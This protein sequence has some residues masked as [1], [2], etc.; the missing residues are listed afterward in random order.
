MTSLPSVEVMRLLRSLARASPALAFTLVRHGAYSCLHE[1]R[2]EH[3][4]AAEFSMPRSCRRRSCRGGGT[5]PLPY[6]VQHGCA[7]LLTFCEPP[8]PL[9][10]DRLFSHGVVRRFRRLVVHR[11]MLIVPGADGRCLLVD[12]GSDVTLS[13]H[14]V[15]SAKVSTPRMVLCPTTRTRQCCVQVHLAIGEEFHPSRRDGGLAYGFGMRRCQRGDHL[16]CAQ[17]KEVTAE[18]ECSCQRPT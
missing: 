8:S 14:K 18:G 1:T 9:L 10:A 16:R 6:V 13:I 7:Q 17:L 11:Q 12:D 5:L 4:R 15:K 2:C 3:R